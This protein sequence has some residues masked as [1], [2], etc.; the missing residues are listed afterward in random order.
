MTTH[1][2]LWENCSHAVHSLAHVRGD[3]LNHSEATPV[4]EEFFEKVP[5]GI[6]ER[7][8][9]SGIPA[10]ITKNTFDEIGYALPQYVQ[11]SLTDRNLQW[12]FLSPSLKLA[13]ISVGEDKYELALHKTEAGGKMPEHDHKGQEITVVST[14]CFSDE[15]CICL[16]VLAAPIKL[17]GVKRLFGPF[18]RISPS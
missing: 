15:E 18:L 7:S 16:S 4:S 14:G 13:T 10:R 8:R 3:L 5:L 2:Q 6:Y 9:E 11:K 17:T 1:L 12:R